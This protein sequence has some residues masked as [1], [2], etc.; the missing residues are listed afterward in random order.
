MTGAGEE[1]LTLIPNR[2]TAIGAADARPRSKE[3]QGRRDSF[4]S[5]QPLKRKVA[6]LKQ[7]GSVTARGTTLYRVCQFDCWRKAGGP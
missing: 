2:D 6:S 3:A 5:G 4:S 7:T 1:D